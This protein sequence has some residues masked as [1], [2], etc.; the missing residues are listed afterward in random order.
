M[1][2]DL[3]MVTWPHAHAVL[4]FN[5]PTAIL[6]TRYKHIFTQPYPTLGG[7]KYNFKSRCK[8]SH[9]ILPSTSAYKSISMCNFHTWQDSN[10]V[11]WP[12]VLILYDEWWDLNMIIWPHSHMV[13][14]SI[15]WIISLLYVHLDTFSCIHIFQGLIYIK[16]DLKS[17]C[18]HSH[19]TPWTYNLWTYEHITGSP[20]VTLIY[21]EI[22]TW[23][24]D[25]T[26][27]SAHAVD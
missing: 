12:Q 13:M 5:F 22:W 15:N 23:S 11:T 25:H 10:M 17:R 9:T 20:Y 14:L 26:V 19:T 6:R 18:K 27:T 16:I 2:S 24:Y 1:W 21:G 4:L 8:H 3:A 7:L